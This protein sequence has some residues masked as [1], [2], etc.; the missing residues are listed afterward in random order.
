[1]TMFRIH[2]EKLVVVHITGSLDRFIPEALQRQ[3][4]EDNNEE[5]EIRSASFNE[6]R[7]LTY[8][9]Y[10]PAAN[11]TGNDKYRPFDVSFENR[12]IQC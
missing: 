4:L 9:P 3:A 1:M 6:K 5:L 2:I 7:I 11:N 8:D 10:C 12:P